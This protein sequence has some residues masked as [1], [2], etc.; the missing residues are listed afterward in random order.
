MKNMRMRAILMLCG[1]SV[2]WG[3][4]WIFAPL[5]AEVASPYAAA[6]LSAALA[7]VAMA[8]LWTILRL[9]TFTV[10][11]VPLLLTLHLVLV[12]LGLPACLMIFAGRH[13]ASAWEILLYAML[14][15]LVAM[16]D[17]S[18]TTPMIAAVGAVLVLFGGEIPFTLRVMAWALLG[19]AAVALQAYGLRLA[20]RALQGFGWT[21]LTGS[22]ALQL[23]V[24]AVLLACCSLLFDAAPRI[25]P[26]GQWTTTA[27]GALAWLALP[28]MAL[29]WMLFYR[30]LAHGPLTPVQ[31]AVGQ[32]M[33]TLLA[34]LESAI[35]LHARPSWQMLVALAALAVCAW[36]VLRP[37]QDS[38]P[39]SIVLRDTPR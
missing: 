14:P 15:L 30:L 37:E 12:M 31:V 4:G 11:S 28:G 39:A 6:A 33:Q 22:L 20:A 24:A 10:R 1:I 13:G 7:C 38:Q 34:V 32:W 19:L 9:L 26:L 16:A 35:L 21:A 3:S 25:A 27:L 29:T 17:Q 23:G 36:M 8:L 2:L 18:W 5:L